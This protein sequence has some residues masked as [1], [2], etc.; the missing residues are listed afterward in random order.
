MSTAQPDEIKWEESSGFGS[1]N[2]VAFRYAKDLD[3]LQVDF[4]SGD[5]YEYQNVPPATHR[6]FQASGSKGEFFYRNIRS[7][8]SYE[9]V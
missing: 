7:R 4:S 3:I 8:F 1:S 9:R 2:I 5:T 6:M